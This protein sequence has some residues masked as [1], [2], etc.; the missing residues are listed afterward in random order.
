MVKYSEDYNS[1]RI[2]NELDEVVSKLADH[3]TRLH[4]LKE[5]TEY[6]S[7]IAKDNNDIS[8][9]LSETLEHLGNAVSIAVSYRDEYRKE[10]EKEDEE[11]I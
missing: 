11:K 2:A 7:E 4:D 10:A 6:L 3:F 8:F 5:K 1:R 9:A